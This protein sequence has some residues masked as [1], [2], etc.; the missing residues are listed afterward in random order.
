VFSTQ[1]ALLLY[2]EN[3]DVGV[4]RQLG[5]QLVEEGQIGFYLDPVAM[6]LTLIDRTLR[7]SLELAGRVC[8]TIE[9]AG[10]R[11]SLFG[12]DG[13]TPRALRLVPDVSGIGLVS[14]ASASVSFACGM[15]AAATETPLNEDASASVVIRLQPA[16]NTS[17]KPLSLILTL[18][19][20]VLD[21]VSDRSVPPQVGSGWETKTQSGGWWFMRI[22]P[23][24]SMMRRPSM[25]LYFRA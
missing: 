21:V 19:D 20:I 9:A 13:H 7:T 8:R 4:S 12:P 5:I 1:T 25:G 24:G 10:G 18:D 14:G 3:D 2:S 11:N 17:L 15:A 22:K 16:T 23:K 6:G